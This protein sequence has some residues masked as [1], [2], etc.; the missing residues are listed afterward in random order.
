MPLDDPTP[1]PPRGEEALSV[2]E[3]AIEDRED[4]LDRPVAVELLTEKGFDDEAATT[5]IDQLLNRGYLYDVDGRLR[6]TN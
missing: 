5:V 3:P 4:G 6:V 1:P 2:L